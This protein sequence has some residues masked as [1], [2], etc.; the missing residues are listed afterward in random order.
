MQGNIT[1]SGKDTYFVIEL[2]KKSKK[3]EI[4]VDLEDITG[5]KEILFK[6]FSTIEKAKEFSKNI[7]NKR[8][9]IAELSKMG[10]KRTSN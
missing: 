7:E 9:T 3:P 8:T 5:D 4:W 6:G 2:N 1:I 10:F